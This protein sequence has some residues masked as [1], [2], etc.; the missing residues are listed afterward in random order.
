MTNHVHLLV[1]PTKAEDVSLFMQYIGRRYVSYI[2]QKYGR[3]GSILA[4]RFK[5]S[6]I[7]DRCGDYLFSTMRYIEINPVKGK[8]AGVSVRL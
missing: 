3:S 6:L 1:T 2:N 7:D 8:Y 5:S 4:G